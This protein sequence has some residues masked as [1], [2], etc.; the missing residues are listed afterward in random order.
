MGKRAFSLV[1]PNSTFLHLLPF[2]VFDI[3]IIIIVVMINYVRVLSSFI[4]WSPHSVS[5]FFFCVRP[6]LPV[7]TAQQIYYKEILPMEEKEDQCNAYMTFICLLLYL[8]FY[9][10]SSQIP[11]M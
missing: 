8:D 4:N 3:L 11:P 5:P 10:L 6:F 7:M 9:V 2:I 1:S